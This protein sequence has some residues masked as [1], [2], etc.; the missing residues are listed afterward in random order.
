M[1]RDLTSDCLW[2]G[3]GVSWGG[4]RLGEAWEW[5]NRGWMRQ[6]AARPLSWPRRRDSLD[7]Q[8]HAESS[9]YRRLPNEVVAHRIAAAK[10]IWGSGGRVVTQSVT[11]P[12]ANL[13]AHL[14]HSYQ[15]NVEIPRT[16]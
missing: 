3:G 13:I 15:G 4:A 5:V 7:P 16:G 8:A 12:I 1:R 10:T 11:G 2:G 9:G 14:P 6:D